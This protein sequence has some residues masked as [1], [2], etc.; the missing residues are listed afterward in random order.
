[1]AIFILQV[2]IEEIWPLLLSILVGIVCLLAGFRTLWRKRLIDD[3]PTSKTQGAFIGLTELKGTAESHN[4]LTSFMAAAHCVYYQWDV[5]EHWR[6]TVH[7]TY[8]DSKGHRR[9]RT[10]VES[11]WSSVDSGGNSIPFY[12]KDDTGILRIIPEGAKIQDITVFSE[13]CRPS[14]PLYY[15]KGPA[16]AVAHSTHERRFV[17]TAIPLH[18]ELYIMGQA[19]ERQDIAAAEIAYDKNAE[20]FLI[21]TKTEK[22]IS[23]GYNVLVWFLFILG[24]CASIGGTIAWQKMNNNRGEITFPSL[25]IAAGA[26]IAAF[27]LGWVWTVYNSLINLRHMAERGWSQVDIQLKRRHDL[28]PN[29]EKV[30][31]GYRDYESQTQKLIT[32][33]RSQID[34]T[35]PGKEGADYK[36]IS[37]MLRAV[38][39]KYPDLKASDS[40]LKLQEALIDT[41]QRIALARDYFNNTSTFYNTRLSIVPDRY[42]ASIA[43]LKPFVLMGA[44]N[45]ERA[46]VEIKLSD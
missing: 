45:F 44:A 43:G 32:E 30:V 14:D 21:S 8:T 18:T 37:T 11:G 24:F 13:T 40:F 39:E 34:A 22:Q 33:L 15:G 9:T 6:K 3:L 23:S 36:G 10:R 16:H 26:Y 35:P 12:L 42:A 41:E 25:L 31:K 1:L 17:E 2:E 28:I 5:Q 4:P 29:L 20:M 46:P 7:E 19:R 27:V 38:V